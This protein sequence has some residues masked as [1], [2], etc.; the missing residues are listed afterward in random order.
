MILLGMPFFFFLKESL[1]FSL[2]L[3]TRASGRSSPPPPSSSLSSPPPFLDLG[4]LGPDA[5]LSL[6]WIE[7]ILQ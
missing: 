5:N 2:D 7:V 6:C 4:L 3:T 1:E